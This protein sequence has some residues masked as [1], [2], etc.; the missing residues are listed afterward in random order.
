MVERLVD[1]AAREAGVD[2]V[3]IRRRNFVRPDQF[4]FQTQVALAYDSGNYAPALDRA[5]RDGGLRRSSARNRSAASSA[6]EPSSASASRPTS[7]PAVWLRRRW[8]AASERRPACGRAP[9][10]ACNPGTSVSVYTGSSAHGQGHETTFA[11]VVADKLG[12][13]VEAVDV[14]HG[15]T[16]LVQ[17]GMGTYGSRSAAV[18][19][20]AI[21][22]VGGEGDREGQAHRGPPARSR[23]R[24]HRLRGRQVLGQGR[25]RQE[26][27]ARR[28]GAPGLPRAQLPR[29]PRARAGGELVLRSFELHV[30]VRH[31]HRRGRDRARHR[32]RQAAAL[33][34]RRR[35]RQRHQPDDR[36]RAAP[37]RHRAGRRPGAVG[38]RGLR[39]GRPARH[40]RADGLRHAARA[41]PG[42]VRARSHGDAVPAQPARGQGRRRGG[43][44]RVAGGGGQRRGRR[45]VAPRRSVTSTCRSRPR[46][47]G[48]Q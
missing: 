11:Q 29:R 37:R 1:L 6:V 16:E 17:Q 23:R 32:H 14:I 20:S 43:R 41:Q 7:R 9:R 2:P 48:A 15:D 13:A 19:A 36:R 42:L 40:R 35:R 26:Q 38:R 4:P 5:L 12:I 45:A 33:R 44:D 8:P 28:S 18:G 24:G 31:A 30:S 39:R 3:E 46:R 22:R 25:A 21:V 27:G 10:C 34:R 47:C